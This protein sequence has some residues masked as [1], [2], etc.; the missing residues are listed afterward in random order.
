[1]PENVTPGIC[2]RP[3]YAPT[4]ERESLWFSN[5]KDD[6]RKAAELCFTCPLQAACHQ[7]GQ[8]EEFGVWGG[9]TPDE[10]MR[11][12]YLRR[13][14]RERLEAERL[15]A[16]ARCAALTNEGKSATQIAEIMGCA[17]RTVMKYRAAAK[18][19]ALIAA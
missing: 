5:D 6:Q 16:I 10:P 4:R 1:M 18:E 3:E 14:A 15:E 9:S 2:E 11:A 12:A 13:S 17:K 8:T 19:S 7:R